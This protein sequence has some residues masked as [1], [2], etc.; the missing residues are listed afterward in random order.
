MKTPTLYFDSLFSAGLV[1]VKFCGMA[2]PGDMGMN[3]GKYT[4]KV[5]HNSKTY[6]AGEE[7]TTLPRY[8]VHRGRSKR[9]GY[10]QVIQANMDELMAEAQKPS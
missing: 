1:P 2:S 6:R 5:L 10:V 8:L 7:I 9:T 3:E 4:V